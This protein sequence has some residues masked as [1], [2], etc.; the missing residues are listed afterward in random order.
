MATPDYSGLSNQLREY[1]AS[2]SP[3]VQGRFLSTVQLTFGIK[4]IRNVQ[5]WV[6]QSATRRNFINR[7]VSPLELEMREAFVRGLINNVPS[8]TIQ[9]VSEFPPQ[10]ERAARKLRQ[11]LAEDFTRE[12]CTSIGFLPDKV[13][14]TYDADS[15]AFEDIDDDASDEFEE[16]PTEPPPP[17]PPPPPAT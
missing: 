8:P 6:T 9:K 10:P 14:Y 2:L 16:I 5:L 13:L 1:Y 7:S 3:S 4:D 15:S 17:P 12:A 11:Y